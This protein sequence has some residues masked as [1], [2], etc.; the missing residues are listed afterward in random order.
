MAQGAGSLLIVDDQP[1]NLRVL[2]SILSQQGY[3][4]RKALN[5]A[6][7][8]ES[9]QIQ[10][11]DLI[12]LDVKMPEMDGYE[13]CSTLKSLPQI[14][15]IPVIFLSAMDST[16]DKVK[17]FTVGGADYITKPFEAEEVLARVQQQLTLQW[18]KQQLQ[19][20]IQE[21]K[22]AQAETQLLL[23]TIQAVSEALDF[24]AALGAMLCK[25]RL[26]I[27]WDYGEAWTPTPDGTAFYLNRTCYNSQDLQLRHFVETNQFHMVSC[28]AGLVGR[29]WASQQPEWI[30]DLSPTPVSVFLRSQDASAVGLKAA[31]AVPIVLD[32]QVLAIMV[33]FKRSKNELDTKLV[34]LVSAIAVQLGGFMERKHSEESLRQANRELQRL[35][36]LDGLTQIANRRYFDEFLQQEWKGLG[37]EQAPLSL[38]LCDIDFFKAYNDHYGHQA[39]DDCLKQVAQAIAQ[40]IRCPGDLAARYGGEEFAVILPNTGTQEAL[41]VAARVQVTLANLNI[42]HPRSQVNSIVTL[43]MGVATLIPT[44]ESS[45][46]NLIAFADRAL[47]TAKDE[48]R[49]RYC[50]YKQPCL[51]TSIGNTISRMEKAD[52]VFT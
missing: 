20:E 18:Q 39:G 13:V 37:R 52:A 36:N 9:A 22:Q 33:F 4:V 35:A 2:A 29:V 27:A 23:T 12:L 7:A 45:F 43:S 31:F 44:D 32:G 1:N 38:I 6:T 14:C 5:G 40:S 41:N 46:D 3:K 48:G 21:R 49:N 26:A 28:N 10:P 51:S 19:Q 17:A 47:Y 24:E 42:S 8:L 25:V 16:A 15:E 11:P 34:Q 30:A 50:S